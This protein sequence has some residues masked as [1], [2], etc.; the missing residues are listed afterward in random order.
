VGTGA[1]RAAIVAAAVVVGA[2]VISK[3]FPSLGAGTVPVPSGNP[4]PSTST[5]PTPSSSQ[6]SA[7][8]TTPS[9]KAAGVKIAVYNATTVQGL[10]GVTADKLAKDGGYVV[11]T[12]GNAASSQITLIYYRDEQGKVDAKL[13][14]DK[15]LKV[16][17]I[18]HLPA[19]GND[20]KHDVEL[21]VVLGADY[22]ATHPVG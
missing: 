13:L 20:F 10:A 6:S 14:R 12:V 17:Q 18:K 3:G 8:S 7:P 9:P 16:G 22:A 21:N 19:K 1:V 4:S 11:P 2:F 15:Y 5:S